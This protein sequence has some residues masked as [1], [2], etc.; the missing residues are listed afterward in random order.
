MDADKTEVVSKKVR[1]PAFAKMT[2]RRSLPHIDQ[3]ERIAKQ[4]PGPVYAVDEGFMPQVL[5]RAPN[6]LRSPAS[7]RTDSGQKL[8]SLSH[9]YFSHS[10]SPVLPYLPSLISVCL[11]LPCFIHSDLGCPLGPHQAL[12]VLDRAAHQYPH[13]PLHG[14]NLEGLPPGE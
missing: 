6:V 14:I 7:S 13:D 2:S 8:S 12:D 3:A 1:S 4:H 5:P 11:W 10:P 9:S